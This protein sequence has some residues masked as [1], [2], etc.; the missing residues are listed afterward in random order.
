MQK[1]KL[2]TR[3][4]RLALV[5]ARYIKAQ[6]EKYHPGI[7]IELVGISTH[8]DQNQSAPLW[9]LGEVGVF[10]KEIDEQLLNGKI[11]FAVHSMKDLGTERPAGLKIAAIPPRELP[12]DVALFC[13]DIQDILASGRPLRIGTSA[14]RRHQ[15]IPPFLQKALP[16][17]KSGLELIALRGNIDTRLKKLKNGELDGIVLAFAGLSRLFEDTETHA[18]TTELLADLCWMVLP[19]T[20]CPGAPGQG[21]LAIESLEDRVDIQQILSCLHDPVSAAQITHERAILK[22]Q[23]G[24][25]HQRFGVTTLAHTELLS[26]LTLIR[27]VNL[28]GAPVDANHVDMPALTGNIWWGSEW[29]GQLFKSETLSTPFA[30]T[31]AVFIANAKACPADL[32]ADTRIW[33]SGT[34]SWFKLA[35]QGHWIEG[36]ADGLGFDFIRLLVAKPLLQLPP[37]PE[38]AVYTHADAINNWPDMQA[39]ATYR[40]I[41]DIQ[42]EALAALQAADTVVWSSPSQ[43]ELLKPYVKADVQH[44]CGPGKTVEYL[45]QAGIHNL[46]ILPFAAPALV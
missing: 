5:Q 43:Y 9:Q 13:S 15:L 36:C 44:A 24:G 28:Q 27:G 3:M 37:L 7:E 34:A 21:A 22:A 18:F 30:Q 8:G 35:Q 20:A 10:T 41:P 1:L 23:G 40:L 29:N 6:L 4:S 45:R 2:G 19:L 42:P 25:C 32:P 31:K 33:V 17:F 39:Y 46:I 12:Y 16:N 26:P 11:N 14:P 38:W